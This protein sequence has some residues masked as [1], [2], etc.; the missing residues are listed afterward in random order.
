MLKS[1]KL[2]QCYSFASVTGRLLCLAPLVQNPT[3]CGA[4]GQCIMESESYL[5][6]ATEI[7][8][9]DMDGLDK[10]AL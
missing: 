9:L 1:P 4:A 7:T 2:T 3:L 10:I 6:A 8:E 5:V